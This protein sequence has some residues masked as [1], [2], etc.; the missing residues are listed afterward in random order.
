MDKYK[1]GGTH[2]AYI[3]TVVYC[4]SAQN[5]MTPQGPKLHLIG[6]M[7]VLTPMFIPGMFSFSILIGIQDFK[8]DIPHTI[9]FVFKGPKEGEPPILDTSDIT[10]PVQPKN[11]T[12]PDDMQGA[13]MNMDFR[14][15]VIRSEGEYFSEIFF[16]GESLGKFPIKA[17]AVEQ[18]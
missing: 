11:P 9:R 13:M 6:P 10:M 12:L 15:V 4:E 1:L 3:T 17:K 2:M 8:L 7:Q 14:N 18:K 5:E 16:D